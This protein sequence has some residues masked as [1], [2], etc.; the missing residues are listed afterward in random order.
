MLLLIDNYD[1]FTYNL[2]HYLGELGAEMVIRRNDA[3]DVQEA[4]AMNPAGILLSPGP[5]DPDQAGICLALTK[6][7]A[8]TKTP[9]LGVCLGH[10]TIGQVFGG[11]VVR[12]HEIVHGKMGTVKHT[13]KGLFAGLPSP[14]EATRYHSLVV[15][16]ETLPD[17]LE[18]TAELDDGTI[19]GLQHKELP[20]HGVQFHPES[21]ASEHGH[22]LLKNFLQELKV[23]A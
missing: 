21:I 1:S 7:A 18:I 16:R 4:M 20:I 22:A 17:C 10:Q 9:L 3:L 23:P 14:F 15:E 6:A 5:C 19:M 12:C 11:K 13:G 2:V 8:E